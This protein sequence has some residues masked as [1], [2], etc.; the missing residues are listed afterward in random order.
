MGINACIYLGRSNMY[1]IMYVKNVCM[2][3]MYGRKER[4]KEGTKK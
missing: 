2:Q 1:I 4:G 3:C